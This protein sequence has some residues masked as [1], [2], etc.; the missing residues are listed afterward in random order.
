M[1]DCGRQL[2]PRP[3]ILLVEMAPT[4]K[5]ASSS[6]NTSSGSSRRRKTRFS[7]TSP[8]RVIDD[9]VAEGVA[10][11]FRELENHPDAQQR[12][13]EFERLLQRL[14]RLSGFDVQRN[15]PIARPRQTDLLAR[16]GENLFLLEAKWQ[17]DPVGIEELDSL[18]SRLR[19]APRG[20]IGCCFS[21]SSFTRPA[22]NR[23][24]ELRSAEHGHEVLLFDPRE[25]RALMNGWMLLQDVVRTKLRALRERGQVL[26]VRDN[27][28]APQLKHLDIPFPQPSSRRPNDLDAGFDGRAYNFAFGELP[29]GFEVY[30]DEAR[31]FELYG[32]APV[33]NLDDL[34][35]LLQLFHSHLRFAGDG[36]Y[37]IT[38]LHNEKTWCGTSADRFLHN[39]GAMKSRHT[40]AGATSTHHSE[41]FTFY[42]VTRLGAL[43]VYG[44]QNIS[45]E[46]LYGVS[47]ELRLPGIPLDSEPLRSVADKLGL[48]SDQLLP[49]ERGWISRVEIPHGSDELL[50][51]PL[52]YLRSHDDPRFISAAV[53]RNPFFS[54]EEKWRGV[55]EPLRSVSV[56]VGQV[57]DHLADDERV[58]RFRLRSVKVAQFR[59]GHVVDVFLGHDERLRRRV[60]RADADCG[61]P[62][63]D[64]RSRRSWTFAAG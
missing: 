10:P 41:E 57:G 63:F 51:E 38:E 34:G 54:S 32:S 8:P 58:D 46:R 7:S 27:P 26:F 18:H 61:E 11:L 5:R 53:V 60:V 43:L 20:T 55:A 29:L 4:R 50:V 17:R 24:A 49:L 59:A 47:F 9:A 37:T 15:P 14:F 25:V 39:L 44:R 22:L 23:A 31:G 19:R 52:E 36:G 2:S 42:D 1:G 45:T 56:L 62:I 12:G 40:A 13:T 28:A 48:G 64:E 30:T 6:K 16:H 21:M 3:A 35:A 33:D